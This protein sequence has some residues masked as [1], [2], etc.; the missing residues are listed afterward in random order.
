[1]IATGF[2]ADVSHA[3]YPRETRGVTA[4]SVRRISAIHEGVSVRDSPRYGRARQ[5]PYKRIDLRNR[6]HCCLKRRWFGYDRSVGDDRRGQT[7]RM[8]NIEAVQQVRT[9][10]LTAVA[11]QIGAGATGFRGSRRGKVRFEL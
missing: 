8:S 2:T 1:M 9:I 7:R 11:I 3:R 10:V 6:N 4:Y 5:V